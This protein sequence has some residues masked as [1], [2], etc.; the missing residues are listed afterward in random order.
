MKDKQQLQK[1]LTEMLVSAKAKDKDRTD[2]LSTKFDG[3]LH[4]VFPNPTTQKA[5]YDNCRQSCVVSLT[6]NEMYDICMADAEE[7]Y[8]RLFDS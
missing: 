3:L 5:D 8:K 4:Q 6:F 2:E 1:L 7:R